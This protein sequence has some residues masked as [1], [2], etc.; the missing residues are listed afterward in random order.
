MAAGTFDPFYQKLRTFMSQQTA[1]TGRQLG[2]NEMYG[3]TEG[4]MS[5]QLAAKRIADQTALQREQMA[6][7]AAQ[8]AQR[9]RQQ[10]L[11]E[12]RRLAEIERAGASTRETQGWQ[13][14]AIQS[15]MKLAPWQ[16]A[17]SALGAVGS[18]G[19]AVSK[20]GGWDGGGADRGPIDFNETPYQPS[21]PMN[22][23]GG[24]DYQW[25]APAITDWSGIT[26]TPVYY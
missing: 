13:N 26:E 6:L 19:T 22:I 17:I 16:T 1:Q 3:L 9:Q 4:E 23:A 11:L 5:T 12:E 10:K 15:A 14:K 7:T 21:G 8:E 24:T 18:L 25:G 2:L 20:W